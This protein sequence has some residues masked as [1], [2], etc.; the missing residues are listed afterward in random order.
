M[1]GPLYA[2]GLPETPEKL[3]GICVYC[4]SPSLL[5]LTFKPSRE[6]SLSILDP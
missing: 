6:I 3:L 1:L 2:A 5:L 4:V